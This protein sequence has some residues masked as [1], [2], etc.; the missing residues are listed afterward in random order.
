MIAV[1][2]NILVYAHRTDSPFHEHARSTI[3]T[4][5]SGVRQWAIPWPCAHEFVAVVTHPRIYKTATPT[6]TAFAQLR[7]L[8]MLANV[9]FIGE[10]DEYL[11]HLES[12]AM[13][14]HT[15]GGAIHDARI[16]AIC[17]SHGVGE[18][19]SADRDFSRFPQL[20]VR[21]PLIR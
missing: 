1:D 18:L 17:I 11:L 16:A 5:A 20:V 6:E 12:L 8:A 10:A 13:A 2:T 7:A 21:N 15:R 9:A 19:W 14:A 4:L 3:E